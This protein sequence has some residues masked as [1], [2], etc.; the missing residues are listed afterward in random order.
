MT[1]N[2]EKEDLEAREDELILDSEEW[3]YLQACRLLSNGGHVRPV[4]FPEISQEIYTVIYPT[5]IRT[6]Y[7]ESQDQIE[8]KLSLIEEEKREP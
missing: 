4:K 5:V 2:E 6:Y 1:Q 8:Y 3:F 7:Y